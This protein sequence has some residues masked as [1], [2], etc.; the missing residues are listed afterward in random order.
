MFILPTVAA[1]VTYGNYR[2]R[3]EGE[4]ALVVLAS[5]ALDALWGSMA[6][7]P[8]APEA[9]VTP[10]EEAGPPPARQVEEVVA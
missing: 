7:R 10:V 3:S 2:F 1:V 9:A 6:G 4:V 8:P 5:V